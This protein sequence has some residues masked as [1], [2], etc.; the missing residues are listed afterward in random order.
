MRVREQR[1]SRCLLP[2]LA[3]EIEEP[4]RELALLEVVVP[5]AACRYMWRLVFLRCSIVAPLEGVVPMR[6]RL[7][8]L[9][10]L[11]DVAARCNCARLRV[12]TAL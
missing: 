2:L 1:K 7:S 12:V 10:L 8:Q 4:E 11:S 5:V 9:S 6:V 3:R